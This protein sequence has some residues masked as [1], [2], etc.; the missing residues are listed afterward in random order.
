ML[1]P[2]D[3][4]VTSERVTA[5]TAREQYHF[6]PDTT[7]T[8]CALTL[9]NGYT[10]VGESACVHEINFDFAMGVKLSRDDARA[11]AAAAIAYGMRDLLTAEAEL[12]SQTFHD[13]FPTTK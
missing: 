4:R 11:K 2:Q 10:V 1:T 6:F 3:L 13:A 8:V 12:M 5:L 7:T 9:V